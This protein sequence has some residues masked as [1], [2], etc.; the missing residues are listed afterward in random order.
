[1]RL[2]D[3]IGQRPTWYQYVLGYWHHVTADPKNVQALLATQVNDFDL[4]PARHGSFAP[5][6]GKG[7]FTTDGEEWYEISE[8]IYNVENSEVNNQ[9]G[10]TPVCFCDLNL[11]GARWR[12]C[13]SKKSMFSIF[14][15][16]SPSSPTHGQPN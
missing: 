8:L 2:Y 16:G 3:E 9:L 1:L 13:N 5:F 4:G 7:I 14:S 12:T 10:G 15:I 6:I 11:R